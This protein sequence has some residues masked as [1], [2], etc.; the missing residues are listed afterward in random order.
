MSSQCRG[1]C[2]RDA[3]SQLRLGYANGQKYCKTCS[4]YWITKEIRCSCC[5]NKMRTTP[6]YNREKRTSI[7]N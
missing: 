6:K 7:D 1:E 3:S 2:V 4:H 5:S